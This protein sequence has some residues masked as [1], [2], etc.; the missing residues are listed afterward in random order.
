[1]TRMAYTVRDNMP[2]SSFAWATA[3]IETLEGEIIIDSSLI[4]NFILELLLET[5]LMIVNIL[6]GFAVCK[7]CSCNGKTKILNK[8]L[9]KPYVFLP[10]KRFIIYIFHSSL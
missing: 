10:S 1:M 3:L 8:V 6:G 2:R 5:D 9:W 7:S 4:S